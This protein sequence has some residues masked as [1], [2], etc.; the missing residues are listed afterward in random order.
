[1]S[2]HQQNNVAPNP[3][4][5]NTGAYFLPGMM[6]LWGGATAPTDWL[7][8]NGAAISRTAY[9]N[10]FAAI[11]TTFGSGD[12]TSVFIT[13]GS[14]TAT[15]TYTLV[16]SGNTNIVVG[17]PFKINNT[18]NAGFDG[19]TF[20]AIAPTNSTT[21]T[22]TTSV[23]GNILSTAFAYVTKASP[24]TFNVPNT[25][26]RTVR[27]VGT[28]SWTGLGGGTADTTAV[29]LG[30]SAGAD[31]TKVSADNLPPHR[32]ALQVP[33]NAMAAGANQGGQA[34]VDPGNV[35]TVARTYANDGT[36]LVT[37]SNAPTL[38]AYVGVNYIIKT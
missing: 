34:N 5:A 18:G 31:G 15:N 28:A 37:N 12:G 36:T 17:T 7:L 9:A 21:I 14:V 27:G 25:A 16:L 22:F 19:N 11:S 1:M 26:G 13:S 6:T 8:C 38:N 2:A 3:S 32:H 33:G 10:L 30:A 4:N 20:T 24:T 23:I 35:V 29:T